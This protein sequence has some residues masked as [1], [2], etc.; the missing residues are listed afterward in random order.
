MHCLYHVRTCIRLKYKNH[1]TNHHPSTISAKIECLRNNIDG[2]AED[3]LFYF[4][5]H[6]KKEK[7]G[8]KKKKKSTNAWVFRYIH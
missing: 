7:K 4:K 8:N 2:L 5:H 6:K 1:V 3:G